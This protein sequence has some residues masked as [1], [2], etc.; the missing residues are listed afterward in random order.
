MWTVIYLY[1]TAST[2]VSQYPH[3]MQSRPL[4]WI[5]ANSL[6]MNLMNQLGTPAW[7][8]NSN[9]KYVLII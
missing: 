6:K 5:I 1:L 7:Y 3:G 8:D 9:A 4:R 2:A